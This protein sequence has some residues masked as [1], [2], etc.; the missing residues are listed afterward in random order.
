MTKPL[1]KSAL[2]GARKRL[3][4]TMQR[5]GFGS[6]HSLQFEDGEPVFSP[7]PRVVR[8]I[9]FGG[10]NGPRPEHASEDFP[11]TTQVLDLFRYLDELRDGTIELIEVKHGVPFKML[12]E[13][14]LG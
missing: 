2:S 6:I 5:L 13:G 7:P 11:L 8:D 10:E 14:D 9:K 4:E 12:V 3:L 1:T